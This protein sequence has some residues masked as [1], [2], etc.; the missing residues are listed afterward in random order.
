MKWS[1]RDDG[2]SVGGGYESGEFVIKETFNS[3]NLQK[4][5]GGKKS[6]YYWVLEKNGIVIKYAHTAKALKQYAETL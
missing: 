3:Y 6:D 1:K 2:G 4:E 5:Y